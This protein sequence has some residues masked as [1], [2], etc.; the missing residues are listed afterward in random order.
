MGGKYFTWVRAHS[1]VDLFMLLLL[2]VGLSLKIYIGKK[3]LLI[4]Y[5]VFT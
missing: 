3:K 1:D 4:N 5:I 2:V